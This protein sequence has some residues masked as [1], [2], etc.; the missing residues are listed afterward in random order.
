MYFIFHLL[1]KRPASLL[2]PGPVLARLRNTVFGTPPL[3]AVS[4]WVLACSVML[5]AATHI[6]WDA[7]THRNSAVVSHFEIFRIVIFNSGGY[8]LYLYKLL[9][10]L[11]TVLGLLVLAWWI[12]SWLD[13]APA[14]TESQPLEDTDQLELGRLARVYIIGGIFAV[15][16]SCG[17]IAGVMRAGLPLERW[18]FHV[19]VAGLSGCTLALLFYCLAWS[20]VGAGRRRNA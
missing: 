3:P 11:S 13:A 18:L 20:A 12:K 2:L 19:V 5:G 1:L 6:G 14:V 16:A 15:S 10:H 17:G 7:F 4:V 8:I 9:Q